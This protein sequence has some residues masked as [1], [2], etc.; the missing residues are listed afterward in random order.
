VDNG[1]MPR[2]IRLFC[3]QPCWQSRSPGSSRTGRCD[4]HG[5][6]HDHWLS[7]AFC[8]C[9]VFL[10]HALRRASA[11]RRWQRHP[12]IATSLRY[13]HGQLGLRRI[14]SMQGSCMKYTYVRLVH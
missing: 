14:C 6:G 8:L 4:D 3:C 5:Y 10:S 1:L 12:Y 13:S 2:K 9:D 11:G 7:K